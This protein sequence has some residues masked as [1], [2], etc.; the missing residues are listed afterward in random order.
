MCRSSLVLCRLLDY[1]SLIKI[2]IKTSILY[3]VGQSSY[4]TH[5]YHYSY[6]SFSSF[7]APNRVLIPSLILP[8]I[9]HVFM[10]TST[11][12]FLIPII[13]QECVFSSRRCD[14]A[15]CH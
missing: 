10:E 9:F 12:A 14:R 4:C 13:D 15:S 7:I 6:Y 3:S 11:S 2:K 1:F 5:P 8:H